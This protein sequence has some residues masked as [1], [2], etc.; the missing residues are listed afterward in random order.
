MLPPG[1][2]LRRIAPAVAMVINIGLT[3]KH[4]TQLH[5]S[6]QLSYFFTSNQS[7]FWDPKWT[8]NPA[9][10][11]SKLLLYVKRHN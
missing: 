3:I 4:I 9:H 8:L 7:N 10:Q 1:E 5:F 11:F 2:C 6:W